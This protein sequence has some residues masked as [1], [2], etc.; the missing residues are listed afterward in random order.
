MQP[1]DRAK[2]PPKMTIGPLPKPPGGTATPAPSAQT[3]PLPA[4]APAIGSGILSGAGLNFGP[5]FV[6]PRRTPAPQGQPVLVTVPG[7]KVP[8]QPAPHEPLPMNGVLEA[9]AKGAKKPV[10]WPDE[11]PAARAPVEPAASPA[12]SQPEEPGPAPAWMAQSG[13]AKGPNRTPLYVGAVALLLAG[14]VGAVALLSRPAPEPTPA[15]TMVQPT[16][17]MAVAP[18]PAPLRPEQE[19]ATAEPAPVAAPEP[20]RARPAPQPRRTE[21]VRT[22]AAAPQ[23]TPKPTPT[24]IQITPQPLAVAPPPAPVQPPPQPAPR[25]VIPHLDPGAPIETRSSSDR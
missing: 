11:I 24:P 18:T 10:V 17:P 22:A 7:P 4:A 9:Y 13:R 8:R 19:I 6:P 25:I 3:R 14:A 16:T 1:S 12:A 20:V 2:G 5:A 23:P 21:P 15:P